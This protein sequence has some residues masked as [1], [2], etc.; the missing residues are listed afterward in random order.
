ML[1]GRGYRVGS[2]AGVVV[3]TVG[4]LAVANARPIQEALTTYVPL[5]RRLQPDVLAGEATR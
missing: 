2:V 4:A 5:V 1:S 3:L